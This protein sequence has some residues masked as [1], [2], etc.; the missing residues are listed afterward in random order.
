MVTID[1][2][3][4]QLQELAQWRPLLG[5]AAAT[6]LGV[7]SPRLTWTGSSGAG[8]GSQLPFHLDS[9]IDRTDE[10][11]S[12]IRTPQGLDE[13][14]LRWALQ[15]AHGKG[16]PQPRSGLAYLQQ[17]G[18]LEWAQAHD[19]WDALTDT[20][21]DAHQA[22]GRITG[23]GPIIIGK[24]PKCGGNV[25]TDPHDYDPKRPQH[26][27][28]TGWG[29]CEDCETWYSSPDDIDR[30]G[31]DQLRSVAVKD[32]IYADTKTILRLWPDD[33]DRGTLY[34]WR[35]ADRV[36]VDSDGRMHL[37]TVNQLANALVDKRQRRADKEDAHAGAA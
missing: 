34:D 1:T 24:C 28:I 26:G 3:R 4:A 20:I 16:D 37:R 17:Q 12:G 32:T 29:T 5:D 25:T 9:V 10:G 6:V 19:D 31:L 13:I 21:R 33:L 22:I 35:D 7:S 14:M 8:D 15:V 23:H 36:P 27:G 30:A 18:V 2:A 11:A